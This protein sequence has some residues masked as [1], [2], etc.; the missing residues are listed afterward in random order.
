MSRRVL[1]VDYGMGNVRSVSNALAASGCEPIVS[2]DPAE[3]IRADAFVLPGVGAFGEAMRNLRASGMAD[4]L[5]HEVLTRR[6][7]I[8]GVCLGMQLLGESSEEGGH[9]EGLGWI[10]ARVTALPA[11]RELRVPHMGWNDVAVVRPEPLFT[12]TDATRTYYFAHSY[13]VSCPPELISATFDYGGRN[14]AAF[15]RDNIFGTQFHPERSSEAGAAVLRNF[16]SRIG[17]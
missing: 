12:G 14:V 10:P 15:Q 2:A 6:K 5:S 13:V 7:P 4:A 9:H 8:L 11:S 1:V 16:A 3:A 17:L